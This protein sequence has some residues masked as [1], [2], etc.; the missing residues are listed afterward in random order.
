MRMGQK[1]LR[2]LWARF[3]QK[4]NTDVQM[5]KN[6][7]AARELFAAYGI[8]TEAALSKMDQIPVSI[9]CWQLDDITGFESTGHALSG[10][11]AVT[12]NA[13]GKA[14]TREQFF[15]MMD[16]VLKSVPG[17]K[18]IGVHA[19]YLDD[20]GKSVERDQIS[21]ENYSFW[22]DYAKARGIGLDFNATFFSHP[23][24]IAGTLSSEDDEI[25]RFWI[26]HG[27]R[28]RK[29]GEYFGR[30]LG[31]T[32]YTNHWIPDG[33]KDTC[34]D[35]LA[36]RHRLA[37]SLDEMF[38]EKI[39]PR[40]N[41]DSVESKLFGLGSES[42]VVGSAEFYE[43]YAFDR[44]NCIVCL[45]SG[46]FHPTEYVS[47]KISSFLVFGQ[48]LML[49]VSRPVRWDSDHVVSLNK[50]TTDIMREIARQDAFDCVHIGLDFFDGTIDRQTASITGSN[51]TKKA[52]LL[53]LLEPIDELRR[54]ESSGD[55]TGRLALYEKIKL[56]PYGAV[57]DEYC[58]RCGIENPEVYVC[59]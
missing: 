53:A 16:N 55:F 18:K 50:E 57:W 54:C 14:E 22:V 42:Y 36:P 30:E 5:N 17:P 31:Q 4:G 8:D 44:R 33:M 37:E 46:H 2:R 49:H 19:I 23:K 41:V 1:T 43:N 27:K 6:Y 13:P 29:V 28:A 35:K 3:C 7:S 26:E 32:C 15:V 56:L 25:R 21:P 40:Y 59:R 11:I 39:D 34:I 47:D 38:R 12:G 24:S 10:G 52:I 51:N 48:E 9:N 45:D 58:R 20:K